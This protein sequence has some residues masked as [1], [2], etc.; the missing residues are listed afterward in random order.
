MTLRE[1]AA[2][3]FVVIF[4]KQVTYFDIHSSIP[5][6]ISVSKQASMNGDE[7]ADPAEQDHVSMSL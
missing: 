1:L 6:Y 4:F 3:S 2:D 5:T 7:K